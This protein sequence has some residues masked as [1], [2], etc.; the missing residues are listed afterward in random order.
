MAEKVIYWFGEMLLK[1]VKGKRR[2]L[3]ART[4]R[5]GCPF[6]WEWLP[7]P[8]ARRD[9]FSGDGCLGGRCECGAFFVVDETGKLGGQALLD[10][11]ALACDGDLDRALRLTAG[12]DFELK[13]K[14]LAD[15][16][17]QFRGR[18]RG[19]N[20]TGPRIWSLRLAQ[21]DG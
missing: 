15:T 20:P 8:V 17:G 4:Y 10:L 21:P 16:T 14:A 7:T 5:V 11:Q 3:R 12:A 2:P 1:K 19:K 6:C 18:V 13:Q 9:V